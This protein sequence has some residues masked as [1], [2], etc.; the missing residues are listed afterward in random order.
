MNRKLG[1][2]ESQSQHFGEDKNILPLLGIE[3]MTIRLV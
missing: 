2:P 3:T 1:G